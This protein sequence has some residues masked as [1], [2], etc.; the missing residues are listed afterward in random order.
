M[1]NLDTC[2]GFKIGDYA[3]VIAQ[4]IVKII[5]KAAHGVFDSLEFP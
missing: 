1:L 3:D 5:S 4:I 2:N